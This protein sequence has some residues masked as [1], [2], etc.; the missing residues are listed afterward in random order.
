VTFGEAE[1]L[2]RWVDEHPG[3]AGVWP[4]PILSRRLRTMVEDGK[5]DHLESAEVLATL[6]DLVGRDEKPLDA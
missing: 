6:Q 2:V 3:I 5:L 4:V 1:E